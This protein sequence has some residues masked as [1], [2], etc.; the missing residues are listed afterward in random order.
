MTSL[1]AANLFAEIPAALPT[2]LFETLAAAGEVRIERIVSRGHVSPPDFLYDQPLHEFVVLLS[3]SARLV[4]EGETS[5]REL[6]P[7]DWILL[8]AGCRHRVDFT[9]P[10]VDTVWLAIH[11]GGPAVATARC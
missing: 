9:P 4:V 6:R 1:A 2:E 3:G 8:P 5:P 11:F 10:E 7:G